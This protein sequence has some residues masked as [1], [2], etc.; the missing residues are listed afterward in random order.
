MTFMPKPHVSKMTFSLPNCR[1]HGDT[2]THE[3]RDGT[4]H[5]GRDPQEALR[6]VNA[7]MASPKPRIA[8]L[9]FVKVPRQLHQPY[10]A[11][12]AATPAD[13]RADAENHDV[14]DHRRPQGR[15]GVVEAADDE[16]AR[17]P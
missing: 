9:D 14:C 10:P 12:G 5:S 2:A 6:H 8:D 13:K 3:Q 15:H 7:G 1:E 4:Q 11:P 17:Q 16:H